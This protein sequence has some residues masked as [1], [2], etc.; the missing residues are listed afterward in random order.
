MSRSYARPELLAETDWLAQHLL[1]PNVRIVDC[2][3]WVAYQRAHIP[4]A[5]GL[6]TNQYLKDPERPDY[7]IPPDIFAELMSSL[8]IGN[9]TLVV[10][11]DG[12]G[13]HYACRL[14]WALDLYGHTKAQVLNGGWTKW[15]AEGRPIT[16]RVPE[17]EPRRF[18][19]RS[20]SH[21]LCSLD[22]VRQALGREGVVIWDVR[23]PEE[24][25]GEDPRENKYGGHIPGAVNLEWR[26]LVTDDD[27]RLWKPA[28]ELRRMLDSLGI[29]AD[30]DVLTH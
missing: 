12:D 14:W 2:D 9:D 8:G 11:Y 27:L 16:N 22:D 23:S 19:V 18:Q 1:D 13:G 17:I 10:A 4:G 28:D 3:E 15:L 26:N 7:V 5:V 24:H 20:G 25:S 29:T 6:L 30:K 21:C